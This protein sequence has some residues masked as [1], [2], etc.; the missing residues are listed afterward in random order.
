MNQR[1]ESRSS[2]ACTTRSTS[3]T[4]AASALSSTSRAASR[5][6]IVAEGHP[7]PGEPGAS[8]R[9]RLRGEH[10]RRRR[11]P[12][13]DAARSSSRSATNCGITLPAPGEYGVGMVFLPTRPGRPAAAARR[14]FEQIVA[15]EGQQLLGWRDV[16]TDNAHARRDR[17]R[18]RAVMRQ[19]FIGR[20]GDARRRPGLRAQALRHPQARR[21]RGP[22]SGHR[23]ARH[24]LRPQPVVKTHRLQGHADRRPGA[25]Y[26]PDLRDPA[27]EIGPGAGALALQH[28]HVPELGPRAS[29][30]LPRAQRRDQHAARQHQ[31]DARPRRACSRRDL[32]GDDIKKILPIIDTDGSD[33]AMFDNC[34]GTAGAGRPLAAA[35]HD[36]DDPRAVERRREHERR[37]RRRSTNITP[38]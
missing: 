18:R 14:L 34:P 30:P 22:Q 37:R 33:S 23:P 9:L 1:P 15:E 20:S 32:F 5:T 21:E 35:R 36:D 31:L 4:P 38:A 16:P 6:T 11:H 17:P 7:D 24:V 28:Q 10:R 8:R 29:V 13:A 3:T 26:Y 2:K 12:H 19:V 27:M 25:E